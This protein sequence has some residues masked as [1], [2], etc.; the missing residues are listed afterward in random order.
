MTQTNK[1]RILLLVVLTT[2]LIAS[3]V[4]TC[5]IA[6]AFTVSTGVEV[7]YKTSSAYTYGS[8][9]N[10]TDSALKALPVK[11]SGMYNMTLNGQYYNDPSTP[12]SKTVSSLVISSVQEETDEWE[13][14]YNTTL[15]FY[16]KSGQSTWTAINCSPYWYTYTKV[17]VS[18]F[19]I[20]VDGTYEFCVAN[21][22]EDTTL[23]TIEFQGRSAIFTITLQS[24]QPLPVTPT[25]TGYTF[26]GWYTDQ[27]CTQLYTKDT[28]TSDITLYAG[29]RAN[30]YTVNFNANGGSTSTASKTVTYDSTY[31][32]LPTPTRTGYTFAGWYNS[33]SGGSQVTSS[34]KVSITATQTLYA[35]WTANSYTVKFDS[36]GGSS[37]SDKSVT[38]DST[39]GALSSPTKTGY[40]F[41]GWYNSASGG[42]QVTSSTK[43]SITVTQTLYARWTANTYTIKFN[44][45]G[46]TGSMAD[47]SMTYDSLVAVTAN[48]FTN[49]GREFLGWAKFEN[50][51]A[52]ILDGETLKENLTS[53]NGETVT[54]YAVWGIKQCTV[55]FM[56]D[57]VVYAVV[58][59]DY[60]TSSADVIGQAVNTVLYEPVEGQELPN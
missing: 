54:L 10:L 56:V 58:S 5:L 37:I 49:E 36:Q 38:Y 6:S 3:L 25:K 41:A 40:T 48:S 52:V 18:P 15:L 59:V 28:V 33:A 32:T 21:L 39:Y 31:G 17:S 57:G 51:S 50:G 2:L 29:W 26:T 46:G 45:N 22:I 16:R 35:R 8:E 34:T 4:G 47:Q 23:E 14:A 55:T 11:S 42:T 53:V 43:V 60:G 13:D 1:T 7:I 12:T 30:T 44:A 9:Y 24:A 19:R 20:T 27:A